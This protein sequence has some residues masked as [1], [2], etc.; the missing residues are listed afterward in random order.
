[1]FI[2]ILAVYYKSCTCG[3]IDENATFTS[4]E[5]T[6]HSPSD[7]WTSDENNHWHVCASC[8]EEKSDE[9]AHTYGDWVV[10]KEA[11]EVRQGERTKTC[12]VCG[13]EVTEKIATVAKD[14][15]KAAAASEV[16]DDKT[17]GGCGATVAG[18]GAVLVVT[19]GMGVT[20]LKKRG[21]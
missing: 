9:G 17:T 1:M 12:T 6:G 18:M 2:A 7:K 5:G 21:K 4:G 16:V 13:H 19:L 8:L 20:V 14:E 15:T 11:T 3:G 10:T